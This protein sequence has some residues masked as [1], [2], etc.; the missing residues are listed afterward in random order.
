MSFTTFKFLATV[1][2]RRNKLLKLTLFS[3]LK[4]SS[5]FENIY[6]IME[7]RCG[8]GSRMFISFIFQIEN[9]K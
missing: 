2:K 6:K 9:K 1:F 8:H 7:H 4:Y 3:I 5:D